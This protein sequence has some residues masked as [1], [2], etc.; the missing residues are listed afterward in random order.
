MLLFENISGNKNRRVQLFEPN[1]IQ[2]TVGSGY[3]KKI[4]GTSG[5]NE[6]P[7]K[8]PTVSGGYLIPL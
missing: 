8:D 1:R 5:L 3:L 6:G 7:E 2:R 4:Q